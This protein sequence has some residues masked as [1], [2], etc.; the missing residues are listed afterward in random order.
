MQARESATN[1]MTRVYAPDGT[2]ANS[3][4]IAGTLTAYVDN[5]RSCEINVTAATAGVYKITSK[6]DNDG[7]GN[8]G[9]KDEIVVRNASNQTIPGRTWANSLAIQQSCSMAEAYN[10][11]PDTAT[12]DDN[13]NCDG[14]LDN[15]Q[16]D[17]H[18]YAVNDAGNIYKI[19]FWQYNGYTSTIALDAAGNVATADTCTSAYESQGHD[20]VGDPEHLAAAATCTKYR[21]FFESPNADLPVSASSVDGVNGIMQIL[22]VEPHAASATL[23]QLEPTFSTDNLVSGLAFAESATSTNKAGTLTL[24]IAPNFTGN[25][26]IQVDV[27]NNGSYDDAVDRAFLASAP[28]GSANDGITVAFD[29]QDGLGHDISS[30]QVIKFRVK[31]DR[32]A[33]MHL[34]VSDVEQLGG[35]TI[36]MMNSS[37]A[38]NA[39]VYWNDTTLKPYV[40]ADKVCVDGQNQDGDPWN[41]TPLLDGTAGVNSAVPGGVHGWAPISQMPCW[42]DPSYTGGQYTQNGWG[43]TRWLDTW[44]YLQADIAS[45]TFVTADSQYWVNFD[46]NGATSET[47]APQ[48]IADSGTTPTAPA[49]PTRPGYTFGGWYD[50]SALSG[51]AVDVGA[52]SITGDTTY[53][54]KWTANIYQI[55]YD[56]N[57][58][59]ATGSMANTPAAYEQN[60]AL[61]SNVFARAGYTFTGWTA[62]ADGSGA[63]YAD[64]YQF[65][66]YQTLGNT[67]VFAQWQI[68]SYTVSFD[69]QCDGDD[70]CS[71]TGGSQTVE[72]G[73]DIA[74]PDSPTRDGYTFDYYYVCGD[75]DAAAFDFAAPMPAGDVSLC[76]KWTVKVYD[77]QFVDPDGN[78]IGEQAVDYGDGATAPALPPRGGFRFVGWN[79]TFDKITGSIVVTALYEK[80]CEYDANLLASDADCAAP[81]AKAADAAAPTPPNTGVAIAPTSLGAMV[82]VGVAAALYLLRRRLSRR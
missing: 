50:N 45:N 22:P 30:S 77:V 4:T 64:K 68:N 47:P 17:L 71:S 32:L 21:L 1:L 46:T 36:T 35:L 40:A 20:I 9:I 18:F 58:S 44:V 16:Q 49:D 11:G 38:G 82:F 70:S 67:T 79:K 28:G 15:I 66:P 24:N 63:A 34:V 42:G 61:D 39:T 5:G 72:Y 52:T 3:C 27:N 8:T 19:D 33:E 76:A 60:V 80:L 62:A 12:P 73:G 29:G 14:Y 26:Q 13:F 43:D 57:S 51:S 69:N 48:K 23:A 55:I 56:K 78:V 41:S 65:A 6:K 74:E 53:Y 10:N 25:Y 75:D 59:A 37:L 31:F 2:V 7:T 81:P 54:A